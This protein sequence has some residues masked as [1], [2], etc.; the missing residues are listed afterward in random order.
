MAKKTKQPEAKVLD[1]EVAFGGVS[2]GDKTARIGVSVERSEISV[3]QADRNICGRRLTGAIL[4]RPNNDNPDQAVMDGFDDE[5]NLTGIFD[6]KQIGITPKAVGFGLTFNL[7]GLDVA[8][9]A[10]FAKRGGHLKIDN[11]EDIPE[12][13]RNGDGGDEDGEAE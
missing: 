1:L 10:M 2:I 8:N 7:Q 6:V 12:A 11:V 13:E 3:T 5:I 9:L 4:A